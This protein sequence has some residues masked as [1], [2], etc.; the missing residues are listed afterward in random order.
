MRKI[1]QAMRLAAMSLLLVPGVFSQAPKTA[2]QSA[3]EE[4]NRKLA[5]KFMDPKTTA[6]ERLALMHDDYVQHNPI[7]KRFGQING[8]HGKEEFTLLMQTMR[9]S[10]RPAPPSGPRPPAGDPAY[11]V[12]ADGDLVTIMQKR[13]QPD[14]QN[15]GSFY[16]AFWF[17]TWRVKDGKLYEHWDA[18]T[19]PA[20]IPEILKAPVKS[21]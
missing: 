12:M 17:D 4:A 5:I 13:Y 15:P 6:D 21:K 3:Q 7:F 11:L 18:A 14:P 2:A 16:E 20:E 8:T 19:I 10:P 1:E 9:N